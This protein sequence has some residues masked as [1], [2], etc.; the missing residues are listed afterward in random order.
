LAV[1]VI[2]DFKFITIFPTI[3]QPPLMEFHTDS[4]L[5]YNKSASVQNLLNLYNAPLPN[6]P[7]DHP[8]LEL[9][10]S[11]LRQGFRFPE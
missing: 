5:V 9:R 11:D 1:T 4:G 3:P 8:T 7:Y 6:S 10:G 2:A